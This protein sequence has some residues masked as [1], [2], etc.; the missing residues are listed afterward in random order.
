M[1]VRRLSIILLLLLV[2]TA[3]TAC[4]NTTIDMKQTEKRETQ[5]VK[6]ASTD[7]DNPIAI[8]TEKVMPILDI[9]IIENHFEGEEGVFVMKAMNDNQY[10]VFNEALAKTAFPPCSTF[11]IPNALIGLELGVVKDKN[12][13]MKWD[14]TLYRIKDWNRDHTLE[15]SIEYSAVWY[16]RRLARTVGMENMQ[17]YVN[18]MD[19]GNTDISGGIEKFWLDSTLKITTYEQVEFLERFYK[20]ELP[21]REENIKMVKEM[22]VLENLEGGTLSGKTGSGSDGGWFVG[23][24][25]TPRE[26][27]LFSAYMKEKQG[28]EVKKIV[29]DI[30]NEG[31]L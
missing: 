23:Y 28:K 3:M 10:I 14:G 7:K 29:I 20:K 15:S 22:I 18:E 24:Y 6:T 11:K 25:E 4:Q 9:K 21:F 26:V 19:Y 13:M 27:Y 5:R 17:K 30:L 1:S 8:E 31:Q 12:T 16:F 2:F